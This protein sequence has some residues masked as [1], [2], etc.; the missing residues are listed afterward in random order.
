MI[1]IRS[2]STVFSP[3]EWWYDQLLLEGT[4]YAT[5]SPGSATQ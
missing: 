1:A 3:V 2:R 4:G 5:A